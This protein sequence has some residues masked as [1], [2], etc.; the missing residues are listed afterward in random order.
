MSNAGDTVFEVALTA[1]LLITAP[2]ALEKE[3]DVRKAA[4]KAISPMDRKQWD[5]FYQTI[6]GVEAA[7]NEGRT[8]PEVWA[9]VKGLA[10]HLSQHYVGHRFR[11]GGGL[12][13]S[14]CEWVMAASAYHELSSEM[15]TK[16]KQLSTLQKE[17]QGDS[18]PPASLREA[19]LRVSEQ[20]P[21]GWT[22]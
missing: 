8:K 14:M 1:L 5:Q 12:C 15:A 4:N 6:Q 7:I 20:T 19:L 22:W 16:K 21:G 11:A 13:T 3:K 17:L 18:P 9:K 2:D 10:E